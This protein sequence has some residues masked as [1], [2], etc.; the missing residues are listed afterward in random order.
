M[1]KYESNKLL[2]ILDFLKIYGKKSY[3]NPINETDLIEKGKLEELKFKGQNALSLFKDM[4]MSLED[5]NYKNKLSPKWLD[6]SNRYIRGYLWSELKHKDKKDTPHY[7]YGGEELFC[8]YK[9]SRFGFYTATT[10]FT[11]QRHT[12]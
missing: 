7:H 8:A 2:E 9:N 1:K 5:E 10:D 11:P 3:K 12:F 6:G 4:C